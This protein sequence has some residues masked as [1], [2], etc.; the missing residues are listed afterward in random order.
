MPTVLAG[1]ISARLSLF[2]RTNAKRQA[3]KGFVSAFALGPS[4]DIND[5]DVGKDQPIYSASNTE[6]IGERLGQTVIDALPVL[7]LIDRPSLKMLSAKAELPLQVPTYEQIDTAR[8]LINKLY[9]VSK[10]ESTGEC[11][12]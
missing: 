10:T 1:P 5:V 7:K 6:R 9:E 8:V 11:R 3:G 4:G 2:F 12:W